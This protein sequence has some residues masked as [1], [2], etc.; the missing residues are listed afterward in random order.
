VECEIKG[1]TSVE[2]ATTDKRELGKEENFLDHTASPTPLTF[3]EKENVART[4]I[5]GL[6]VVSELKT[7]M[8]ENEYAHSGCI[9][10][11]FRMFYPRSMS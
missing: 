8:Y 7:R 1:Q 2:V 5:T 10:L 3:T 11:P 6:E 4:I 9:S